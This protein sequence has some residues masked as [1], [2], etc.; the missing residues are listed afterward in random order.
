MGGIALLA[1]NNIKVFIRSSQSVQLSHSSLTKLIS[2]RW[3]TLFAAGIPTFSLFAMGYWM[4][5][6]QFETFGLYVPKTQPLRS[7]VPRQSKPQRGFH[8][9]NPFHQGNNVVPAAEFIKSQPL[10]RA[11]ILKLQVQDSSGQLVSPGALRDRIQLSSHPRDNAVRISL[12]DPNT[13]LAAEIVNSLMAEY[14]KRYSANTNS[15]FSSFT[16]NIQLHIQHAT[17]LNQVLQN[18]TLIQPEESIKQSP[19]L[20]EKLGHS[21]S[22]LQSLRS[23]TQTQLST[24]DLNLAILRQGVPIASNPQRALL[25]QVI[26]LSQLR[27]KLLTEI[28][29]KLSL[30]TSSDQLSD[31]LRTVNS[32]VSALQREL[33]LT[34]TAYADVLEEQ[35]SWAGSGNTPVRVLSPARLSSSGTRPFLPWFLGAGILSSLGVGILAVCIREAKDPPTQFLT[36]IYT[37][38]QLPILG[39]IPHFSE[40]ELSMQTLARQ[41]TIQLQNFTSMMGG[42]HQTIQRLTQ[43]G[44]KIHSQVVAFTSVEAGEGKGLTIANLSYLLAEKG[45]KVLILDANLFQSSQHRYW[46]R[47]KAEGLC[48]CITGKTPVD[49]VIQVVH[50]NLDVIHSGTKQ[51][52]EDALLNSPGMSILMQELR[53]RYDYIFVDTPTLSDSIHG[54][55]LANSVDLTVLVLHS[56]QVN[57]DKIVHIREALN[58]SGRMPWGLIINSS[59]VSPPA[60]NVAK[61]IKRSQHHAKNTQREP[62]ANDRAAEISTLSIINLSDTAGNCEHDIYADL[63]LLERQRQA[64]QHHNLKQMSLEDLHQQVSSAW[65]NWSHAIEFLLEQEEEILQQ[66][67]LVHRLQAQDKKS[68]FGFTLNRT[69]KLKVEEEKLKFLADSYLG[70]IP[71]LIRIREELKVCLDV[72]FSRSQ[73]A[74]IDGQGLSLNSTHQSVGTKRL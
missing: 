11:V 42:Y 71:A 38:T 3:R 45:K 1:S 73:S 12:Y 21:A 55:F 40:Q 61:I 27:K 50:P 48:E 63:C 70:Q 7:G 49:E 15:E 64:S 28:R 72:L 60:S 46:S 23:T 52:S 24:I 10:L 53:S 34:Q 65:K 9:L 5:P 36:K 51:L 6:V 19:S 57:E 39:I 67:R 32:Q 47:S 20:N 56:R 62:D 59:R 18:A 25:N 33:S 66:R 31:Q 74:S 37:K 26:Q 69:I 2:R 35:Q 41:E 13:Q 16:K 17:A 58:R 4:Q 8:A 14:V 43:T 54:Y 29:I 22:A 68:T 44:L 30:S